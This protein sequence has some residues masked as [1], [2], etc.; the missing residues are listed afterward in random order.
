MSSEEA[1][2]DHPH[3]A[4]LLRWSE[5]LSFVLPMGHLSFNVWFENPALQVSSKSNIHIHFI[6]FSF[7][8]VYIW[9]ILSISQQTDA[10]SCSWET[11]FAVCLRQCHY[12][13]HYKL[14]ESIS[15]VYSSHPSHIWYG[16]PSKHLLFISYTDD[17]NVKNFSSTANTLF[18]AYSSIFAFLFYI[19]WELSPL[20]QYIFCRF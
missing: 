1:E 4:M 9:N 18:I 17:H 8:N 6:F 3:K 20:F 7:V 16:L 12:S 19:L 13:C 14:R 15:Y 5:A 11:I 10:V 2:C